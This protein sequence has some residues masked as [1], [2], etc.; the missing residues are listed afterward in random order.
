MTGLA[1]LYDFTKKKP[2]QASVATRR[3]EER[4]VHGGL[5]GAEELGAVVSRYVQKW[6]SLTHVVVLGAGHLLPAD[7]PLNSQAMIE[8]WVLEKGQFGGQKW[9]IIKFQGN[10]PNFIARKLVLVLPSSDW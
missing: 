4:E 6:R 2:Y 5:L 8:D 1:T 7:Q 9:F 3:D 10:T